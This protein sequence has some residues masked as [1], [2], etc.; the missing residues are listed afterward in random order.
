MS[1]A[2]PLNMDDGTASSLALRREGAALR[3]AFV[4]A[5]TDNVQIV[6]HI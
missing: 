6:S 2:E 3:V 1:T 5:W 4:G